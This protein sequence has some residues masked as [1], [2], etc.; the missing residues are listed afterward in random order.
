MSHIAT[1]EELE[2]AGALDLA[3]V[4]E[5][6]GKTMKHWMVPVMV[7][8]IGAFMAILD[9]SIVN[10]ATSQI[11]NV[12]GTTT[13]VVQWIST[14]YMLTL[15]VITPSSG[16]LGDR[17]GFKKVYIASMAVF[18]FGSLLCAM[19]GSINFLI[20]ARVIQAIGGGMIMPITMAMIYRLV[21]RH[22][23]GSAM[24]FFGLALLFAPSLGPTLGGYLVEYVDWRWIF[25]I[26][27]PVG[28]IGL[29]LSY[30]LLPEFEMPP[31][32]KFDIG[33]GITSSGGLFCLLLALTEGSDW[34][35]TSEPIILLFYASVVLLALF[36]Y[37][38]LTIENPLLELRV[39]AIPSFTFANIT[40][41][42][43]MTGMF[44]GLFYIPLFLQTIRGYGA[45]ETGLMMMPGA[46]LSGVM[47]PLSGKL[48]DKIGPKVMVV[49]G[50]TG[51]A[52]LTWVFHNINL[53]TA[54]GTIVMWM[55]IRGG[56]MA[57]ANMPAQTASMVD[58]PQHLIGRA[59]ALNNIMSRVSSSFGLAMLTSVLTNRIS[60]HSAQMAETITA[61][62]PV[63]TSF[64]SHVS[65]MAGGGA[66]GNIM[67]MGYIQGLVA[68]TAFVRA[69][70][71]VFIVAALIIAVGIVPA[72]FLKKG[73]PKGPGA[74]AA[75]MAE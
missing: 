30:F 54:T 52:Y 56:I 43:T 7:A 20:F 61:T 51:F 50:L 6:I 48:Y 65:A 34:G 12:F 45:L 31:A 17:F 49:G 3:D 44:A 21:P 74:A 1:D 10:V 71:D 64:I 36:V 4:V 24:G 60:T 69:I 26:N 15:G 37:I 18:V 19:A 46:L 40:M 5:P 42:V 73:S 39:F 59:S 41:A 70:D 25:T 66:K 35:W 62:N 72:F 8:L 32:G 75:T 11:M 38:E 55:A 2:N 28:I 68:K 16:W 67:A 33:G 53:E 27:L 58:I 9:S 23:I 29:L 57:F 22:E 13:T 63:A 14:I 47:M